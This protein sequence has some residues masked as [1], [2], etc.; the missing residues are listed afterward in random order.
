MKDENDNRPVFYEQRYKKLLTETPEPKTVVAQVAAFDKDSGK[1][2]EL[3]YFIVSGSYSYFRLDQ[4]WVSLS[5]R[6]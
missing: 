3:E 5:R 1:N 2:A 6:V 4:K